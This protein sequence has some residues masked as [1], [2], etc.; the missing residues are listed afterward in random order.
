LSKKNAT[1]RIR[2]A[3]K[4]KNKKTTSSDI[5]GLGL[6]LAILGPYTGRW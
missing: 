5:S 2:R 6:E 4:K 3:A 1:L